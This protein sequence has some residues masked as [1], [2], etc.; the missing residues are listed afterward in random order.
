MSAG[1]GAHKLSARQMIDAMSRRNP[2]FH[3]LGIEVL[4]AE[5]GRTK[6]AMTVR[7]ELANTFDTLHG[8]ILF[9]LADTTFGMT[10]NAHNERGVTAGATIE[11]LASPKIGE[12]V[13][14]E[15]REVYRKGR[16]VLIDVSLW[17]DHG[18]EHAPTVC[19]HVRG[20]MRLVGGKVIEEGP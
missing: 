14:S 12:R 8:G 20:R 2:V 4:E 1:K 10:C 19:A 15:A 5:L 13:V 9:A 17:I 16:N 7:K 3:L 11:M 6:L 18:A